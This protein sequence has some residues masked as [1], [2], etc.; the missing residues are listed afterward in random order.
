MRDILKDI[1]RDKAVEL[2]RRKQSVSIDELYRAADDHTHLP[3]RESILRKPNGIIAEFKRRSPSKGWIH[4]DADPAPVA[5]GYERGGAAA[6]S[7]LTD[8]KYFGGTLADLRAAR[9]AAATLPLLRKDFIID[10]YQLHEARAAGADAVLLI[11]AVLSQAECKR[12]AGIAHELGLE[13]L[14]E[15]HSESELDYAAEG[16]ADVVGVNN[17]HL[18]TFNTSTSVSGGLAPLF[19]AAH[20]AADTPRISESGIRGAADIVALQR[21]GYRGFL[22]GELLM[23]NDDPAAALS[24]LFADIDTLIANTI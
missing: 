11:A 7:V 6:M 21:M 14:L 3:F 12:L 10:E 16:Y 1:V 13:T 5:E 23:R 22:I 18:G 17:R 20:V 19:A 4:A 15:V 24:K 8:E 2:E 9:H